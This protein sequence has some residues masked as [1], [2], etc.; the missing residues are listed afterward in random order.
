VAKRSEGVEH[1]AVASSSE[2]SVQ[3]RVHSGYG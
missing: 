2:S 1:D 3:E